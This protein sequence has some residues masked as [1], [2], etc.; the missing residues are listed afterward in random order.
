MVIVY[1]T[2]YLFGL[3]VFYV[4]SMK[5]LV[6]GGAGFI[7]SH[8]V[9]A[10]VMNRHEV[11]VIDDLSTGKEGN[12]SQGVSLFKADMTSDDLYPIFQSL[13]PQ[14]VFH[15]AA[16][17]SVPASMLNPTQDAGVNVLGTLNV[18]EQCRKVGVER[19]IYS[20]TGGALYGEPS[21]TPCTEDHPIRPL[22]PYGVSKYVGEKYLEMFS[23]ISKLDYVVLRYAN[24]YGPRQDPFGEAGVVSIFSRLMLNGEPPV[25]FGDGT[26][27]RDFIYVEDVACANMRALNNGGAQAFNIG[28]GT[29]TSINTLVQKLRGIIEY[30]GSP[31]YSEPRLGDVYK[32]TLDASRANLELGWE[33]KVSLEDGLARTVS[34]IRQ[35]LV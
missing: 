11:T 17:A 24:V 16:Q 12:L 14:V 33:P 28:C 10:L 2:G 26:Q 7:G 21:F 34:A 8:I 13:K 19:V 30:E 5:I 1:L 9:D 22:S 18:L 32:I 27:E 29:G 15:V 35:S 31:I 23:L 20:S 3:N 25:I 4:I 6:T